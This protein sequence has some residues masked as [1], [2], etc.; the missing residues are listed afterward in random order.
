MPGQRVNIYLTG[1]V[2]LMVSSLRQ[3]YENQLPLHCLLN[4]Q[5]V[6]PWRRPT[7]SELQ[8]VDPGISF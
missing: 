3:L 4:M 6:R 5:I 1:A 7:K 2:F 8:T